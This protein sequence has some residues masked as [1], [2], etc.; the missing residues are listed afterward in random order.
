MVPALRTTTNILA[1][2]AALAAV[3]VLN[4]CTDGNGAHKEA[5]HPATNRAPSPSRTTKAINSAAVIRP[6]PLTPSVALDPAATPAPRRAVE[7][8]LLGNGTDRVEEALAD[9]SAA[10]RIT[11]PTPRPWTST[12]TAEQVPLAQ[13]WNGKRHAGIWLS[14]GNNHR[15]LGL[16]GTDGVPQGVT[17]INSR[18]TALLPR[19]DGAYLATEEGLYTVSLNTAKS[20]AATPRR[21]HKS[22]ITHATRDDKQVVWASCIEGGSCTIDHLNIATGKVTPAIASG[23]AVVS[24]VA[25]WSDNIFVAGRFRDPKEG[26]AQSP[27]AT[28]ELAKWL[29]TGGTLPAGARYAPGFLAKVEP[30]SGAVSFWLFPDRRP[31]ELVADTSGLYLL[32]EGK[33]ATMF[34]DGTLLKI[35]AGDWRVLAS[36]LAMPEKLSS[37]EQRL[38]WQTMPASRFE[39]VCF[40]HS[41][42]QPFVAVSRKWN[43]LSHLDTGSAL[44]VSVMTKGLFRY[45]PN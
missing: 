11:E 32:T 44:W 42:K 17:R 9:A 40:D 28:L 39:V 12:R 13:I 16:I 25:I 43:V 1:A 6:V 19:T 38:C 18:V 5:A 14:S 31:N 2:L 34:S 21:L 35:D 27:E 26:I 20:A 7:W 4:G 3:M 45:S 22:R 24:D 23:F 41:R 33:L 30:S 36:K 8:S 10:K 29:Q 37:T 15:E